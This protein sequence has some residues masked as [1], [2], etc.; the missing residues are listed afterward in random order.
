MKATS[1]TV[2]VATG[3]AAALLTACVGDIGDDKKEPTQT[4]T[5]DL[6]PARV[7]RSMPAE[8]TATVSASLGTSDWPLVK[9]PNDSYSDGYLN[10]A[11][12]LRVT[13]PLAQ[14]LWDNVPAVAAQAAASIMADPPCAA[15]GSDDAASERPPAVA[16]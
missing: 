5:C 6:I 14:A 1:T 11:N 8:Y 15:D 16:G 13:A 10:R 4:A 2:L 9:F 3:L 12:T 7:R